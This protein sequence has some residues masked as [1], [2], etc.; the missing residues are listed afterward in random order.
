M[1]ESKSLENMDTTYLGKHF[2]VTVTI[3]KFPVEL[4]DAL[5]AIESWVQE[6]GLPFLA[7][8]PKKFTSSIRC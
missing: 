7:M 4:F 5:V 6:L 2:I 1:S 8:D 3:P